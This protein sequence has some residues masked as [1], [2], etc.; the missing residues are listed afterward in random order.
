[1]RTMSGVL[2]VTASL[3]G[4]GDARADG[5]VFAMPGIA[6]AVTNQTPTGLVLGG[7]LSIA[8]VGEEYTTN[9]PASHDFAYAKAWW[10]GGYVDVVRDFGTATTR[11]TIGPEFGYRSIG[12]DG[13]LLFDLG[14]RSRTGFVIRPVAT[15]GVV[16]A[17]ARFGKFVDDDPGNA[18]WEFG[19]LV[20]LPIPIKD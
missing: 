16:A 11:A 15:L 18:F 10:V 17:F 1:M 4:A 6:V 2:A 20:K 13:G 7:E 14:N 8:Y 3:A 19:V 9:D 5:A 12:I